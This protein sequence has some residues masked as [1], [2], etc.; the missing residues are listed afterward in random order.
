M[1]VLSQL[2]EAQQVL[3]EGKILAYPTEAVMGLGCDPFNQQAVEK[4]ISLKHRSPNKGLILLISS[5]KQLAELTV[6][7]AEP[8][9]KPVRESWPGPVTWIFPKASSIPNYLSMDRKTIAIR[10]SDHPIAYG[11]SEHMPVVST[12][13]NISGYPPALDYDSLITQFPQGIDAF[14]KGDLGGRSL[15]SSI[16]DVMTGKRYR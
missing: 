16:F 2:N 6:P 3:Q 5:W 13:A 4:L 8:L 15:P 9:L 12:S 10:M 1:N 11:L 7:V 14:L